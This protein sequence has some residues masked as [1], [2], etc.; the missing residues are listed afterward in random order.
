MYNPGVRSADLVRNA[1]L[2]S[3]LTQAELATRAGVTQAQI[4]RLEAGRSDPPFSTLMAVIEAAGRGVSLELTA[5]DVSL[6]R[7]ARD[8][9]ELEPWQRVAKL[10]GS[11]LVDGLRQTLELA[12]AL[13]GGALV[14]GALASV[15]Q[16]GVYRL[17][18][19]VV[20][21]VPARAQHAC[22][23]LERHGWTVARLDGESWARVEH[24]P[25]PGRPVVV[26]VAEPAGTRG[27]A[28]LARDAVELPDVA[29]PVVSIRDLLRTAE[30]PGQSSERD[31]RLEL[32]ALLDLDDPRSTPD[33]SQFTG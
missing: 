19:P 8:Q 30:L 27:F 6:H 28:D 11:D 10:S 16:G 18:A 1:R 2:S 26:L 7:L 14:T 33:L 25:P 22:A 29:V 24:L 9:L 31:R 20:E 15:L 4:S 3:G 12:A 13:P 5:P 32:R 21:L 17:P 23:E